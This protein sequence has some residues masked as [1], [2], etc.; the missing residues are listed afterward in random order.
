[1][2]VLQPGDSVPE[3]G[4][5]RIGNFPFTILQ[6]PD[7]LTTDPGAV[8]NVEP[9]ASRKQDWVN[10]FEENELLICE[11]EHEF[12]R[13]NYPL[14]G[15]LQREEVEPP[16][17]PPPPEDAHTRWLF[18]I[19]IQVQS[20]KESEICQFGI[21][22]N[23]LYFSVMGTGPDFDNPGFCWTSDFGETFIDAKTHE[24][25]TDLTENETYCGDGIFG[26]CNNCEP[27]CGGLI[28][29]DSLWDPE[30]MNPVYLS[31][32][33]IS[34]I[35]VL[36]AT[37]DFTIAGPFGTKSVSQEISAGGVSFRSL[38]LSDL[39]VC[40]DEGN[41][42]NTSFQSCNASVTF[43]AGVV[44][45]WRHN[46]QRVNNPTIYLPPPGTSWP[47]MIDDPSH[48]EY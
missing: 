35:D 31:E 24:Y 8:D 16:P 18:I 32:N 29:I 28:E 12:S 22:G 43:T 3:D 4:C 15:Y 14:I 33:G 30:T 9:E 7:A 40:H 34:P 2:V 6:N 44:E 39:W 45:R 19:Q 37:I 27:V 1:M 17:P 48:E 47:A 41:S 20:F 42:P 23:C 11:T 38:T 5:H 13:K 21:R 36:V 10:A 26:P 25:M 46:F